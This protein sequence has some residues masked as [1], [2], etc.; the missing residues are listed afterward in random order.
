MELKALVIPRA[1]GIM[2]KHWCNVVDV[3]SVS[4]GNRFAHNDRERMH[5]RKQ[6]TWSRHHR[7]RDARRHED[8]RR[9]QVN[10]L[11]GRARLSLCKIRNDRD[12]ISFPFL[13]F[14]RRS[15]ISREKKRK[16]YLFAKRFD[17]YTRPFL[18]VR[19]NV[20][21][22]N[23]FTPTISRITRVHRPRI[24][25]K[26]KKFFLL[27]S[28]TTILF[29]ILSTSSNHQRDG[30][31]LIDRIIPCCIALR[32]NYRSVVERGSI[33]LTLVSTRIVLELH[34]ER[35]REGIVVVSCAPIRNV[36]GEININKLS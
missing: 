29:A 11:V 1:W 12:T 4:V 6:G 28:A 17:I 25:K 8:S 24:R 2:V 35:E 15:S 26:G 34:D 10:K 19:R 20:S 31:M 33:Q 13:S 32:S 36:S 21:F 27:G 22:S 9:R 30:A 14:I 23:H 3:I 7:R 18:T 16:D 5:F